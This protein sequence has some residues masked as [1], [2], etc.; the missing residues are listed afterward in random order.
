MDD[1]EGGFVLPDEI[2]ATANRIGL[3][4]D[5]DQWVVR[6]AIGLLAAEQ[7]AG[8]GVS[9]SMNLTS[10]A[11]SDPEIIRVMRDAA[12]EA[13]ADLAGLVIEVGEASAVSDIQRAQAFIREAKAIGC[14]FALDDFGSG[15]NSFLYL[16]HLPVDILKIDESLVSALTEASAEAHFVRA[17]VEM[18]KGLGIETMAE[19]VETPELLELIAD[20]GI[21]YAQGFAVAKPVPAETYL[22]C[23]GSVSDG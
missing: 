15:P 14:R 21:D 6:K 19:N 13:G 22:H 4:R 16:K 17:I 18:C 2:L 5:I 7:A 10:A 1:G 23:A 9:L 3:S 11:L 12:A 8:N 20:Y